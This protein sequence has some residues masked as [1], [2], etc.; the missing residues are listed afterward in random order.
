ML[1]FEGIKVVSNVGGVNF[2]GCVVVL[3]KVCEVV[4]VNLNVVVVIGD[5]FMLKVKVWIRVIEIFLYIY[6]KFMMV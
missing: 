4:G 1:Y 5:D 6:Y 3:K 2:Y